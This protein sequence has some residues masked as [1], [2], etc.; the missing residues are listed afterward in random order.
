MTID[1]IVFGHDG[2]LWPYFIN[3]C[4]K[5]K[6][7][8]KEL[9]EKP[10]LAAIRDII[11]SMELAFKKQQ[12]TRLTPTKDK[13][14]IVAHPPQRLSVA[15][16][17]DI[18]VREAKH[19]QKS[20]VALQV[21][22]PANEKKHFR[23]VGVNTRIR[24]T[25]KVSSPV[26]L[27]K[28]K[29]KFTVKVIYPV[30]SESVSSSANTNSYDS[31]SSIEEHLKVPSMGRRNSTEYLC[32]KKSRFYLRLPEHVYQVKFIVEVEK[33]HH[34]DV[35][36]TLKKIRTDD[37]YARLADDFEMSITY[38]HNIFTRSIPIIAGALQE[39]IFWPSSIE[40]KKR[41]PIP[42]RVRYKNVVSIIDCLEIEIEKPSNPI[43]QAM[44]W[45]DYKKCNTLKFLISSTPDGMITFISGA[46][47]GRASDKEIISQSNFLNELPNACA[48]MADRG[49]KQIDFMLA[50]K[51]CFLVRPPSVEEGQILSKEKIN[52]KVDPAE[53]ERPFDS[54]FEVTEG[55][56]KNIN[57][58]GAKKTHCPK[59]IT[60][61]PFQYRPISEA[62]T[63]KE[64]NEH[65]LN[66]TVDYV[67]TEKK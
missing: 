64:E 13:H 19:V 36:I 34:V 30:K 14:T 60:S 5:S 11:T 10:S 9:K 4:L 44:T 49:F 7:L 38:I 23:S 47:G 65:E 52:E 27:P 20:S 54:S 66:N 53:F 6:D 2:S 35:L 18:P 15:V 57:P 31:I 8:Q 41:L 43:Y 46:F 32:E 50:K 28:A 61:T 45:S 16:Q 59:M 3:K 33:I 51:N 62:E 37:V 1:L 39:L 40:I 22:M 58:I 24:Q 67:Q 63:D 48:V 25:D 29:H 55:D 17:V 12:Q 56:L 21:S 26:K 42:F